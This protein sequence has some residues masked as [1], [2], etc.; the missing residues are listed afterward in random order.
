MLRSPDEIRFQ[1]RMVQEAAN[2]RRD[3]LGERVLTP[4]D[5][6]DYWAAED[7]ADEMAELEA[8][9]A[10]VGGDFD[11]TID[12]A[13]VIGSAITFGRLNA[14]TVP[15]RG[16]FRWAARDIIAEQGLPPTSATAWELV[17]PVLA[18]T[19]PGSFRLRINRAPV[20][21]QQSLFAETLFDQTAE[22][23]LNVFRTIETSPDRAD[24]IGT[25]RVFR[26]N[27]LSHLRA[28]ANAVVEGGRPSQMRWRGGEPV[29][30]STGTAAELVRVL[31]DVDVDDDERTV[32][33]TFV[34]GD[35][36]DDD[37]H[38]EG[39]PEVAGG[40]TTPFRGPATVGARAQMQA[41]GLVLG[42]RVR[43]VLTVTYTDSPFMEEPKESYSLVSI[44]KIGDDG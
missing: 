5:G 2:L 21:E 26:R 4:D 14:F 36:A 33:G 30:V 25:L 22:R 40:R 3:V 18:E 6:W 13:G 28:I 23:I 42:N 8:E 37:F 12:G 43:A 29:T 35:I 31:D 15:L 1:M 38:I 17:E 7:D 41:G 27:T 19:L 32:V 44:E 39:D 16:V 20:D 24:V 10:Q 34:G 9:L 11:F